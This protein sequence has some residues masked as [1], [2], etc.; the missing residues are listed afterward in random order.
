M[1]YYAG[2]RYQTKLKNYHY[3][4][5]KDEGGNFSG[6]QII[7]GPDTYQGCENWLRMKGYW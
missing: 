6:Y 5:G 2:R 3:V 1:V 7:H 4:I